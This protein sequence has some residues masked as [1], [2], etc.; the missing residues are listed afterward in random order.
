MFTGVYFPP[1]DFTEV[2]CVRA[3]TLEIVEVFGRNAFQN[4]SH[5]AHSDSS[6]SI[7]SA[8]VIQMACKKTHEFAPFG[9]IPAYIFET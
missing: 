4:L 5:A 7:H 8:G 6:I 9:L 1:K 3:D 2:F